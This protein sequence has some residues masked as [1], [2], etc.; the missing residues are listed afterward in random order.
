MG[1]LLPFVMERT[2]AIA[3]A[4]GIRHAVEMGEAF[5]VPPGRGRLLELGTFQAEVLASAEQTAEEFSLLLTQHEPPG[6]GP[7]LHRHRDSAEAFFVLEGEYLMFLEEE[8]RACPVGSFVYVPRGVPHTFRVTSSGPGRKLN[9][10]TPAGMVGFF[11]ELAAAEAA[12]TATPELLDRI[13]EQN[14]MEVLGPVPE[15][16]L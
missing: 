5:V 10:F 2:P 4:D 6:F 7:P 11:E 14:H 16:Y 9:L 3:E 13:A 8:Q 1:S 15:T 12:G